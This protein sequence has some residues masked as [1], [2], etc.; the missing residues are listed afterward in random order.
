MLHTMKLARTPFVLALVS[1]ALVAGCRPAATATP[2]ATSGAASSSA[3][4]TAAT[5]APASADEPAT[6]APPTAAAEPTEAPAASDA[7]ATDEPTA[8]PAA[9]DPPPADAAASDASSAAG[10]EGIELGPPVLFDAGGVTLV[11]VL[12]TNTRQETLSFSVKATFKSG[13]TVVG[14]ALGAVHAITPG[15]RRAAILLSAE[16]IAATFDS[17]EAT[18]E[19]MLGNMSGDQSAAAKITFGTPTVTAGGRTST[20]EVD[21]TNGDSASHNVNVQSV[22]LKSGAL[23]GI[24]TGAVASLEPGQTQIAMMVVQGSTEGYDEVLVLVET[25]G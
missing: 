18:V 4:V 9:D 24:G 3:A 2:T 14:N 6:T 15:Q 20:V 12:V 19:T 10:N 23:I 8:E 5:A 16:P 17:A 11:G 21:V 22:F 7:P 1:L 13:D 25:I